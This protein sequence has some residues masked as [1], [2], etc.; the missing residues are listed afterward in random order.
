MQVVVRF[1]VGLTS[2]RSIRR[3][4]TTS[5]IDPKWATAAAVHWLARW[6]A[7]PACRSRR[8]RRRCAP[9]DDVVCALLFLFLCLLRLP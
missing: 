7:G 9:V 5:Q 2:L 6:Q 1:G 3:T 8:R 4:S